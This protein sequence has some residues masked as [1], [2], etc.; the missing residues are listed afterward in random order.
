MIDFPF[1][2][3]RS[4]ENDQPT[5]PPAER[6]P[7]PEHLDASPPAPEVNQP[8]ATDAV[9][10]VTKVATSEAGTSLVAP[11][12]WMNHVSTFFA[13]PFSLGLWELEILLN[14]ITCSPSTSPWQI[15]PRL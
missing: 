4:A 14:S 2:T 15:L 10:E 1:Y 9:V 6:V 3:T 5:S 12:P 11:E 8:M 13:C 7:T